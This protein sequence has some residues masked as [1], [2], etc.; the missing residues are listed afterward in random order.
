[1]L[2]KTPF[3]DVQYLDRCPVCRA[4]L[5]P[6]TATVKQVAMETREMPAEYVVYLHEPCPE[7]GAQG[8]L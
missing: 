8:E 1:M 2:T 4:E 7:C 6:Y 5:E 3:P